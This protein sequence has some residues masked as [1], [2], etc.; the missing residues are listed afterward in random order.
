[1]SK[2]DNDFSI[3]AAAITV[4]AANKESESGD[5]FKALA[6]M[7]LSHLQEQKAEK[8]EERR[9]R[10]EA[11]R[12]GAIAMEN[13]RKA[14]LAVQE[15]CSHMKPWGGSAIAGQRDHQGTFHWICQYCA[16][17]WKNNELPVTLRIP[18]DRVGGP[19]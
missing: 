11:K 9:A 7:L 2:K 1:M 5:A 8:D 13:R 18:L 16:K 12:Q 15:Q 6:Q 10:M 14:E 3:E 17:E 4:S 19:A